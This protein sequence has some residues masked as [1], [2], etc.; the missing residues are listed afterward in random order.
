MLAHLLKYDSVHGILN[1]EVSSEGDFLV[2]NG[3]N[4]RVFAEKDPSALPWKEQ[5]ID[6]VI[7][8]YWNFQ[9]D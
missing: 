4:I 9:Y 7:E 6:I 2:V 8:S 3:K 5:E 1:A